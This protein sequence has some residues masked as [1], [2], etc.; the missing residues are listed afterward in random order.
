MPATD[1]YIEKDASINDEIDRCGTRR[2]TPLL[3]RRDVIIVAERLL[4]LR[5]R[6]PRGLRRDARLRRDGRDALA[7]RLPAP[8]GRH[9]VR[10][11]RHRLP[12]RHLPRARRRRGDLPAVR[13][14][15]RAPR[16]VLRRRGRGAS[17]RS[18]PCGARSSRARSGAMHLPGAA[19]T[20][21]TEQ[22]LERA[23]DGIRDELEERLAALRAA[24]QA[25][26]G[27]AARA[28][29]ALRPRDD[30]RDGLLPGI[31][32]Y[33]RHLDGREARRAAL[34]AA[35]LLPRG[36][37]AGHRREPRHRAAD[38]RHVPRRPRP[39][40][41]P[42]RVRLPP[43]LRAR[44][45]AAAL[46]GVRAARRRSGSTSPPRPGDYELEKARG[47]G[48]RADHPADRARRSRGRGAAGGRP[49]RRPARRDPRAVAAR[50]ARAGDHAHQ[51]D[52]RGP[53]RLLRRAGRR[54][55][56]PALRH[57]HARARR[58]P[59]RPAP[60]RVRRAGRHQPAARGP[61]PPRGVAGRDPRRGQGGL[62]ALDA[63]A[64]PD[65]RAR[66]AQRRT[67]R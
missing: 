53:D 10:A 22:T 34:H 27:A 28:A 64:D 32:N 37:P 29:H 6:L 46:R 8:A 63:L 51:A 15:P 65:H 25:A 47:R 13:G 19:T 7:R 9:P 58:D 61:R 42:G 35:R 18:T 39:Q 16:R 5:P 2:R 20:S 62:P 48:G 26:R 40:G 38:R 52:G 67:A 31:E 49:G 59:A 44:Q 43:A 1:T 21:R 4:H 14:R 57:R 24:G 17:R 23:I 66:R 50:R 12:P 55:P 54:G 33:S 60:G 3:T 30:A 11:Q 36:L 56:L 41:D 45:P